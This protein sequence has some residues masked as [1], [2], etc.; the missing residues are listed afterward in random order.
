LFQRLSCQTNSSQKNFHSKIPQQPEPA[1]VPCCQ[2]M[3]MMPCL[4]LEFISIG[5]KIVSTRVS[6]HRI[7]F[8]ERI[9]MGAYIVSVLCSYQHFNEFYVLFRSLQGHR[10]GMQGQMNEPFSGCWTS[11]FHTWIILQA[12]VPFPR[13]EC[14]ESTKDKG[15]SYCKS[16]SRYH[17]GFSF[18]VVAT[19]P[20]VR[21][22]TTGF[23]GEG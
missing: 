5:H 11:Q 15:E 13:H 2:Y 4:L 17:D 18:I 22:F 14:T 21:I 3:A 12:L 23:R 20:G 16:T 9:Y 1:L 19:V 8:N 6:P 7:S 10:P